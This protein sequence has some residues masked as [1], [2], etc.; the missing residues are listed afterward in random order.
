MTVSNENH[1]GSKTKHDQTRE[2]KYKNNISL[3]LNRQDPGGKRHKKQWQ[4]QN[5]ERT[6]SG[7]MGHRDLNKSMQIKTAQNCFVSQSTGFQ[8]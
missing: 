4:K 7:T 2:K 1:K 3:L 5:C 6:T 8:K